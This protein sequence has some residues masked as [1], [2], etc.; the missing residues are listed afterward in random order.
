MRPETR[1]QAR[2]FHLSGKAQRHKEIVQYAIFFSHEIGYYC[3]AGSDFYK[4]ITLTATWRMGCRGQE[5]KPD[6]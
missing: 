5:G 4:G 2:G 1:D 3:E 6:K